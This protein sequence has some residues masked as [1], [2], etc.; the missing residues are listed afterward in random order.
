ML[1]ILCGYIGVS[2]K[3][4]WALS[5]DLR[6]EIEVHGGVTYCEPYLCT[7]KGQ[8]GL[9]DTIWI[10]FDCGHCTDIVP[11]SVGFLLLLL[12][13][14][15]TYKNIDFVKKELKQ[16]VKQARKH[17]KAKKEQVKELEKHYNSEVVY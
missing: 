15:Q 5:K 6:D 10:G 7:L 4:P 3:H 1:G 2:D 17:E 16:L 13:P 12:L 11:A 8:V 9:R 14:G